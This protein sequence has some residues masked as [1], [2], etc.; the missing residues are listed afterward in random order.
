MCK[1]FNHKI[2]KAVFVQKT[3]NGISGYIEHTYDPKSIY[4]EIGNF[5]LVVL[6]YFA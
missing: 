5:L 2:R 3:Q 6:L 4:Q 1:L